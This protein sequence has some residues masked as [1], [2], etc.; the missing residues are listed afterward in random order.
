MRVALSLLAALLLAL[1]TERKQGN[2]LDH[3]PPQFEVLTHF[4]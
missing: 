4:G 1:P 3:L 2:P